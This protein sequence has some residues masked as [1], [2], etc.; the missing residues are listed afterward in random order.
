LPNARLL[1]QTRYNPAVMIELGA[2]AMMDCTHVYRLTRKLR[3]GRRLDEL[4]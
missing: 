2:R 1:L 4:P 3:A